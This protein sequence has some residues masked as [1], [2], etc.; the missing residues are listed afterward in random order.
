MQSATACCVRRGGPDAR[1]AS[2]KAGAGDG[3]GRGLTRIFRASY[4]VANGVSSEFSAVSSCA[5]V[6]D[7]SL[8]G[9]RTRRA[10]APRHGCAHA[11]S[12]PQPGCARG[13]P[14]RRRLA[15]PPCSAPCGTPPPVLQAGRCGSHCHRAESTEL[16]RSRSILFEV[17]A[18]PTHIDSQVAAAVNGACDRAHVIII[19]VDHRHSPLPLLAL[20]RGKGLLA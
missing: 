15:P 11:P 18:R 13:P 16:G 5:A 17:S 12:L 3:Q 7:S 20:A 8:S 2:Y 4:L 14:S 10:Q 19:I 9:V 6:V 1:P